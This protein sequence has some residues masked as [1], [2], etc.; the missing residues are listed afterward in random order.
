MELDKIRG[1]KHQSFDEKTEGTSC[2]IN[3]VNQVFLINGFILSRLT[4]KSLT[5]SISELKNKNSYVYSDIV[6]LKLKAD[7]VSPISYCIAFDL[8]KRFE[9]Y[10]AIEKSKVIS[11][12]REREKKE[13]SKNTYVTQVATY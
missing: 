2:G 6:P 5:E 3:A 8:I 11:A 9:N 10:A 4:N 7:L 12:N 1:I 13:I